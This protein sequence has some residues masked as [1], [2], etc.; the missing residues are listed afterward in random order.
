MNEL[1]TILE[2]SVTRLF[3]DR[4]DRDALTRIEESGFPR[5]LWTEVVDQGIHKVLAAED[6]GGMDG[7]WA[8]AYPVVRACGRYAV[9]L[10][11]PEA[12]I[13]E[14]LAR[15]AACELPAGVPGL[16]SGTLSPAALESGALTLSDARVPWGRNA[17]FFI[18]VAGGGTG[19]E[20]IVAATG[21]APAEEDNL[22]RDPRDTVNATGLE[23]LNRR[24][25]DAPVDA[26]H[27]LGAMVR[28]AQIAGAGAACLELAVTYAGEREQFGRPL[29]KFQAIQHHLADLAGTMASVDAIAMSAF[30]TL[31]RTGFSGAARDA[32]FEIAAAK[33]RSSEAVEKLTRL[34]H[35]V[36]GA[37]GFTYE[38]GLHFLTRRLWSWRAEFGSAGEWAEYLGRIALDQGG[39][40]IWATITG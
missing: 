9:P 14:W 40:R 37:I 23:I 32:R 4:L 39:D 18:G 1:R 8:D 11:V 20:L 6:A 21:T 25:L 33:C 38:Y 2:D 13:A 10:P 31:D 17:D 35:Q 15:R 22:G 16:L 34:S 29:S 36:H 28:S 5:E 30:N 26:V 19:A 27:W 7:S 3:A 24:P 12:I